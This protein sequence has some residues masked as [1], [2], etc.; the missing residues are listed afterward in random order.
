MTYS[1][2]RVSQRT[3]QS[4]EGAIKYIDKGKGDVI[5]L[6][7][8]VPTSGWL[9]RQM[10]DKLAQNHR[11]IVPD[12]LGFG[13]SDSPKGY[14]TYSEV[15]HAERLLNLMNFLQIEKWTHVFHD[16][17][18]LWTWELFKIDPHRI[19][20]LVVLNTIIYEAGFKPPIRFKKGFLARLVMW[21]YRNGFTT[22]SMLSGLFKSG[23]TK[24]TLEKEDLEGYKT[25]L[26]EGKTNAMYYFFTRTCNTLPKYKDTLQK[27]E[28]PVAVVWGKNDSFLKWEPQ[29]EQV[30][31][32]LNISE[33]NIHLLDAKH[34][35]QE[36]QPEY[37]ARLI[38]EFLQ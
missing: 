23:I 3:F 8:G 10:I 33:E 19:K 11:V 27:I 37:I 14:E 34:F 12:M 38:I 22:N 6:L 17:G 28:L 32:S 2:F 29:K 9:Y 18:G 21:S 36:E 5:L 7:H 30:I 4:T 25:P 35:I 26:L 16:A 24:N 31:A 13:S 1:D 20:K 15:K